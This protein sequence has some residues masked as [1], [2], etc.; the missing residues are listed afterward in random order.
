MSARK[1]LALALVICGLTGTTVHADPIS[2]PSGLNNWVIYLAAPNGTAGT[3]PV[4]Y[5]V[6]STPVVTP[7]AVTVP[8]IAAQ[9]TVTA[10][11]IHSRSASASGAIAASC[12]PGRHFHPARGAAT[13]PGPAPTYIPPAASAP[14]A[15]QVPAYTPPSTP[16]PSM[17][18]PV[19]YIP[20]A[21]SQPASVQPVMYTPPT[22]LS[23]APLT[24][25]PPPVIAQSVPAVAPLWLLL[26]GSPLLPLRHSST[27]VA[28]RIRWR[29]RSPLAVL[30]PGTTAPS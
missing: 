20:P 24:A 27:S 2:W 3:G 14:L 10:R 11:R 22:G 9:A 18:Q 5:T 25:N 1:P 28:A 26:R 12:S 29:P 23:N 19:T 7:P 15:A 4:N 13:G 30:N 6:P 8:P 21:S 17:V 16:Q